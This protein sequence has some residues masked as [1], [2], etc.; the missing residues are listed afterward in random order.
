MKILT[1]IYE[2]EGREELAVW[3]L[4]QEEKTQRFV[5]VDGKI[6]RKKEIIINNFG[7]KIEGDLSV[8]KNLDITTLRVGIDFIND[9]TSVVLIKAWIEKKEREIFFKE[10]VRFEKESCLDIARYIVEKT[11]Y[12]ENIILEKNGEKPKFIEL[13][14]NI[15]GVGKSI[16]DVL[17]DIKISDKLEKW[18]IFGTRDSIYKL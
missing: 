8:V 12:L 3:V 1:S 13:I 14:L 2:V 7:V 5:V 15:A 17:N 10:Q 4:G 11:N 9:T 6:Q 16:H 18:V